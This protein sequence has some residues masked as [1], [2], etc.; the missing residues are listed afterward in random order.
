MGLLTFGLKLASLRGVKDDPSEWVR[1][2]K[3]YCDKLYLPI[4]QTYL[5]FFEIDDIFRGHK[6]YQTKTAPRNRTINQYLVV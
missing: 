4:C 1:D 3:S 6:I 2:D 5:R